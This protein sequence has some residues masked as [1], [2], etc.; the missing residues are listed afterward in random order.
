[1]L[2]QGPSG[3][4]GRLEASRELGQ[5]NCGAHLDFI[6]KGVQLRI[7]VG[8]RPGSEG[9]RKIRESASGKLPGQQFQPKVFKLIENIM[10][11]TQCALS[12]GPVPVG[13]QH[14]QGKYGADRD[15]LVHRVAFR[16]TLDG[17]PEVASEAGAFAGR[18]CLTARGSGGPG[19]IDFGY[20][21]GLADCPMI[22]T[23]S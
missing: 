4:A 12:M 5:F 20:S 1:V 7:I 3:I 2:F 11:V 23:I 18:C 9:V 6:E 22:G 13:Q 17:F 14:L 19:A 8:S 10:S 16:R 21:H 15:G